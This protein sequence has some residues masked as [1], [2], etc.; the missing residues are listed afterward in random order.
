MTNLIGSISLAVVTNWVTVAV[1]HPQ[2]HAKACREDHYDT[3]YQIGTIVTN[4]VLNMEWKGEPKQIVLESTAPVTTTRVG[5]VTLPNPYKAYE[6]A[7]TKANALL[8]NQ[9]N[10]PLLITKPKK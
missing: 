8:T 4:T 9:T 3:H 7:M 10:S 2:C 5:Q 6:D 1:D